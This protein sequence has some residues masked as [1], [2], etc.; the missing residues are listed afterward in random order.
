MPTDCRIS[1]NNIMIDSPVA[2]SRLPVGSSARRRE[3]RF[4]SARAE[5]PR[6]C[7]PPGKLA[8]AM[9]QPLFQAH[10]LE[11]LTN[12]PR[13]LPWFRL[14]QRQRKLDIFL[15]RH[16]REQVKGLKNHAHGPAAIAR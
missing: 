15:E 1:R 14:C 16:S 9:T 2:L 10:G 11:R 8:A 12:P 7:L 13:T 3:G 6:C 5:A 4:T